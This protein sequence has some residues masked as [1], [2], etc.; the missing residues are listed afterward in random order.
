MSVNFPGEQPESVTL[1][2]TSEC[3]C[4]YAECLCV[5][6][7]ADSIN[8]NVLIQDT[9]D[10]G[11]EISRDIAGKACDKEGAKL[12]ECEHV[13]DESEGS[14]YKNDEESV[15]AEETVAENGKRRECES[16][17]WSLSTK[18][19]VVLVEKE[20]CATVVM[21][22][23]RHT[24]HVFLAD[25]TV[26]TGN[27]QGAYQVLQQISPLCLHLFCVGLYVIMAS[28]KLVC[29]NKIGFIKSLLTILVYD[30]QMTQKLECCTQNHR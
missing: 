2:T 24:A 15:F 10:S 14:V 18:E 16:D 5:T 9:C 21:Y 13:C 30:Q 19:R 4:G 7:C 17:K 20:G 6:R 29:F 23:E 8:E 26:I 22:P 3:T 28:F 1:K 12:S 11:E 25:G 27:N